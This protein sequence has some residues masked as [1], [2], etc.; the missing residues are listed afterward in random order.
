MQPPHLLL[1][2]KYLLSDANR[3]SKL[4]WPDFWQICHARLLLR[5]AGQINRRGGLILGDEKRFQFGERLVTPKF[6]AVRCCCHRADYVGAH[7]RTRHR[8]SYRRRH[9]PGCACG[10]LYRLPATEKLAGPWRRPELF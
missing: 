9:L 3:T 10:G 6:K 2:A 4:R 7:G 1:F 5:Q 8:D